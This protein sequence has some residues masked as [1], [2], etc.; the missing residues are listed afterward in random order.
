MH[1][2][3]INL[4]KRNDINST[5]VINL[6]TRY[7]LYRNFINRL[8]YK[9]KINYYT[10]KIN[11][12]KNC[13]R[14]VWDT[15]NEVTGRK[16]NNKAFVNEIQI[17]GHPHKI[18]NDPFIVANELV[19]YF[20]NVGFNLA[21]EIKTKNKDNLN[22]RQSRNNIKIDRTRYQNVNR[23]MFLTP[24]NPYEIQD[25][26]TGL[27]NNSSPGHDGIGI[28]AIKAANM[29][30]AKPLAHICNI[31]F[32]SGV[33]PSCLKIAIIIPLFKGNSQTKA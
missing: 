30:I 23:S 12:N 27:K 4:Q 9:T 11:Q 13:P 17:A 33:F 2:K 15:I 26:I 1:R 6:K 14:K 22:Y 7:K 8:I 24:V 5:E 25:I 21:N 32:E 29:F 31:C 28:K 20:S 10:D 18:C 19:D 16:L 3:I